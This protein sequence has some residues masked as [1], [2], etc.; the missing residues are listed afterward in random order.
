MEVN[1]KVCTNTLTQAFEIMLSKVPKEILNKKGYGLFCSADLKEDI[2]IYKNIG[3]TFLS[4]L[5]K[6]TI[7]YGKY[8]D[9]L[10]DKK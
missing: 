8:T 5:P 9:V 6:Q 7:L 3:V 1:A 10:D 2:D 4:Q